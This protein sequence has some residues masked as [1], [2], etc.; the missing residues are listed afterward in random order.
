MPLYYEFDVRLEEI[1]PPIRRR[2]LIAKSA[3]FREL[4]EAIQD[5]F[6]WG[7]HHLFVFQGKRKGPPIAG[8]PSD[9]M[10]E[11]VPDARKVKLASYFGEGKPAKCRYLY[12]FGDD[13]MHEVKC[14]GLIRTEE[15]FRRR[16]L[17][18]ARAG[19]PDDCGGVGGYERCVALALGEAEEDQDEDEREES[20]ELLEWLGDWKPERFV[21]KEARK[22]FDR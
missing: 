4:S 13:W 14:A 1:E 19:P 7:G 3:T 2:F 8:V 16:L 11:R 21:L 6:G 12:D 18:G 20:R 9:E 22:E 17:S 5:A 10:L 15:K